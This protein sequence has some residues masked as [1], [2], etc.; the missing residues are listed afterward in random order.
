MTDLKA[1]ALAA[2]ALTEGAT[3]MPKTDRWLHFD[4]ESGTAPPPASEDAAT[5]EPVDIEVRHPIGA[6]LSVRV[7]RELGVALDEEARARGVKMSDIIREALER[8]NGPWTS[9]TI[10][11]VS[12]QY[13]AEPTLDVERVKQAVTNVARRHRVA[14]DPPPADWNLMKFYGY[15]T[16][17]AAMDAE[18]AAEYARLATEP[19]RG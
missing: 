10:P 3:P 5:L 4:D 1:L 17:P 8:R 14:K 16:T 19:D 6:V 7:T 11:A 15:T 9:A 2:Y 12:I 13:P 18:I